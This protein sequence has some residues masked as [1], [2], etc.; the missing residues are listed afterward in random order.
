MYGIYDAATWN[1]CKIKIST[2]ITEKNTA[3]KKPKK[4]CKN[5][6][7]TMKL[8]SWKSKKKNIYKQLIYEF[9]GPA[10]NGVADPHSS[11]IVFDFF[12]LI[13]QADST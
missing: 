12:N 5:N 6:E 11:R 9:A 7:K 13:H 8:K 10:A 1:N 3:I 2:K 4:V